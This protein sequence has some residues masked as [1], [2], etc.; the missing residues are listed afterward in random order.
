MFKITL[1]SP[2]DD[3]PLSVSASVDTNKDCSRGAVDFPE[4]ESDM[5]ARASVHHKKGDVK[6]IIAVYPRAW[7]WLN[8]A[9]FLFFTA[10]GLPICVKA[11]INERTVPFFEGEYPVLN[12]HPYSRTLRSEGH[13]G[14]YS[15][16]GEGQDGF[17]YASIENAV[18]CPVRNLLPLT[19]IICSCLSF[20]YL[21]QSNEGAGTGVSVNGEMRM[22]TNLMGEMG[23]RLRIEGK[24]RFFAVI[25]A[26]SGYRLGTVALPAK[27]DDINSFLVRY[28]SEEAEN[29]I[30]FWLRAWRIR[31]VRTIRRI[32]SR[33]QGADIKGQYK[34]SNAKGVTLVH[35]WE[36]N[37]YQCKALVWDSLTDKEYI[38][39]ATFEPDTDREITSRIE[40]N[41]IAAVISTAWHLMSSLERA[42]VFQTAQRMCLR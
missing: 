35:E 20:N 22:V 10:L 23:F 39:I 37:V 2:F 5:M 6:M 30:T 31:V 36:D 29:Q 4:S 8:K 13:H 19:S 32:E 7:D 33:L 11:T 12:E 25:H 21:A 38:P 1:P 42:G 14:E 28:I 3:F 17:V 41:L 27:I 26:D 16:V 40:K 9:L 34:F 18:G 24:G 15:Y